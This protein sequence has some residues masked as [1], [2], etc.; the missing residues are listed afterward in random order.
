MIR[1]GLLFGVGVV[2]SALFS[3]LHLA[4]EKEERVSQRLD[5]ELQSRRAA[6]R[7]LNASNQRFERIAAAVPDVLFMASAHGG[8][9]YLNARWTEYTGL[10]SE[11]SLGVGWR[12]AIHPDDRARADASMEK[13]LHSSDRYELRL[14]L[15]SRDG[16]YRTFLL[17][18]LPARDEVEGSLRWYGALTDVED[19]EQAR[20]ALR[21][22]EERLQVAL[23]AAEMGTFSFD[24]DSLTPLASSRAWSILG[25]QSSPPGLVDAEWLKS[26]IDPD[27]WEPLYLAF[28][29]ASDPTGPRRFRQ[30]VRVSASGQQRHVM[31]AAAITF[32]PGSDGAERP[33]RCAG[34]LVDITET[35]AAAAQVEDAQAGLRLALDA[36]RLGTW[37]YDIA[38]R[39][40][41]LYPR[42]LQIYEV[43]QNSTGLAEGIYSRIDPADRDQVERVVQGALDPTGSGRF[44]VEHRIRLPDG[45]V[46]WVAATGQ[47]RFERI[48][49]IR[50]PTRM[51]GTVLDITERRRALDGLS[52]SEER[53]RL[54]AD[55][56][57]GIIYDCDVPTGTVQRSNGLQA[58]LGWRPD[59]VPSTMQWW[60]EQM[61]P[62]DRAHAD[63]GYRPRW[64]CTARWCRANIGHGIVTGPIGISRIA[65]R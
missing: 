16:A 48:R 46:R 28:V 36:T 2:I 56:I 9:E 63:A 34:T 6:E 7:A 62:D 37:D 44:E 23:D 25:I 12:V 42:A 26:R 41:R 65:Q 47:V 55:A 45:R 13:A 4:R 32:V 51:S 52:E 43:E 27:D 40:F 24:F 22:S 3:A 53:F 39:Q 31:V 18:A 57:D 33:I 58:V 21:A 11:A 59:Q 61:H 30:E 8:L 35:R 29:A 64:R 60:R 15:R 49:G 17:R 5:R 10:A 38:T 50:T 19:A 14:R 54:A 1:T 20:T